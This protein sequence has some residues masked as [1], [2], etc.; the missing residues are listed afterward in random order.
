MQQANTHVEPEFTK[1]HATYQAAWHRF[2]VAVS[3]CQSL[4]TGTAV[5]AT[6]VSEAKIA[7]RSAEGR[8]RQ[9]RN[10]FAQH[11]LEHSSSN[12]AVLVGST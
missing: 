7:V 9:A 11:M 10:A 5:D 8:Y 1:L 12:N 4:R 2:A 6:A 3:L